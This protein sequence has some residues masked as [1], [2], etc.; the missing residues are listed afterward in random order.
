MDI[1]IIKRIMKV[2]RIPLKDGK[3]FCK[4]CETY[5]ELDLMVEARYMCKACK[6]KIS[7]QYIKSNPEKVKV[8]MENFK[9]VNKD[10]HKKYYKK[11][12]KEFKA[13]AKEYRKA[14]KEY[15]REYAKQ[16]YARIKQSQ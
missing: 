1:F 8:W 5:H 3:K 9:A 7:T 4:K 6:V 16:Y 11:Y 13:Y 14:N 15:F 2:E 12:K 10:Y